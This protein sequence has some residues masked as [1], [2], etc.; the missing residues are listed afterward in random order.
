MRGSHQNR[1][2][3]NARNQGLDPTPRLGETR[4]DVDL[5]HTDL[6]RFRVRKLRIYSLLIDDSVTTE[7]LSHPV[8]A[9]PKLVLDDGTVT[10]DLPDEVVRR[11]GRAA[12]FLL[13]HRRISD[14]RQVDDLL[15]DAQ[16]VRRSAEIGTI[17]GCL[18]VPYQ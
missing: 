1:N 12:R 16:G 3:S 13:E 17:I 2:A 9:K 15:G 8:F 11:A 6:P 7:S 10:V 14:L 5:V 18:Y 4:R